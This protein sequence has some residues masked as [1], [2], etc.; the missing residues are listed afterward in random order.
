M[1]AINLQSERKPLKAFQTVCLPSKA[2][3]IGD[4]LYSSVY[5]ALEVII[6]EMLVCERTHDRDLCS[7]M[8]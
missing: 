8:C 7:D 5:N 1:T 4:V 2:L 6:E 3:H